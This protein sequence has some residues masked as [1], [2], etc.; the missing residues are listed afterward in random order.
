MAERSIII[1]ARGSRALVFHITCVIIFASS[2]VSCTNRPDAA[3]TL[4]AGGDCLL[5]RYDGKGEASPRGDRRWDTLQRAARG[6]DA[7]L[8]NLETTVGRGGAPKD[9]RFVFRA[10]A[11]ALNPLSRFTH[12]IAALGNN[13]SMDYGPR[14]LVATISALDTA[15]IAHAGAGSTVEGAWTEARIDCPGGTLAVLSCGFDNDESSFSDSFGAALAPVNAVKLEGRI[16]ECRKSSLAVV[17]MLHWGIEYGT[18]YRRYE[19]LVARSLVDAGADLIV[20]TGPHVLQGLEKYHGALI[21]YSLGNLVFDDL[22]SDE[23]SATVLVR[24]IL[25]PSRGKGHEKEFDVAPLRTR[26]IFEGPSRP[27]LEDARGIIGKIAQRS[28]DPSIFKSR[29]SSKE[30]ALYWFSI[31]KGKNAA[32]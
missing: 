5:D 13:H 20:G 30:N 29:P 1:G 8:I 28:P 7:F 21:C 17:V 26:D 12:P 18:A 23:T 31:G 24:M 27:T 4:V 22:H 25:I 16:K 19:Q 2:T 14:G 32:Y 10:P 11:E 3:L 6:S 9:K 15:G